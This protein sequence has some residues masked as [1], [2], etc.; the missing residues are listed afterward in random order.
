M[1]TVGTLF[2]RSREGSRGTAFP[3]LPVPHRLAILYLMTPLAVWLVG[4][5][6][7]WFG[8]PAAALLALGLWQAL[9]G[10]WRVS[11]RP[12]HLVLLLIAAGWVM[13]TAAGGVFDVHNF[14]WFKHR[15]LFLDLSNGSWPTY[16]PTYIDAPVLLRYYI[17]YYMV[18][19][20]LSNLFGLATLNWAVP[21]WTWCGV[22]LML[23][24]FTREHRGWTAIL[25]AFILVFFSG[26]DIVRIAQFEGL[27]WLEVSVDLQG[28]P[29]IWLGER[30]SWAGT[31]GLVLHYSPHMGG[32]MWVPQHFIA[33]VLYVLLLVQ[34]FQEPRFLAVS[35]VLL[36]TSLFWSPFV[37]IGLLPMVVA[38]VI[39]NGMRP[40]LKW[41][42]L[43]LALP[44]AGLIVAYLASG[45]VASYP[46]G[47][48]W[49]VYSNVWPKLVR[50]LPMVYLT[51]FLLLAIVIALLRPR[52][53]R[54][55]FYIAGLATLILLPWIFFGNFN[56]LLLRATIPSLAL[57]SYYCASTFAASIYDRSVKHKLRP[58][59]LCAMGIFLSVGAVTALLELSW[60]NNDHDF[61]MRRYESLGAQFSTLHVQDSKYHNQYAAYEVTGLFRRLLRES[62]GNVRVLERGEQIVQAR[63][64]VYMTKNRLIYVFGQCSTAEEDTRFFLHVFPLNPEHLPGRVHATLDF[65][66]QE[67]GWRAEK[68]CLIVRELPPFAI[69]RIRTGQ[70]NLSG[71]AHEWS[72]DYYSEQYKDRLLE[73]A[74][75]PLLRAN[76]D[77]YHYGRKL[78]YLKS[79]CSPADAEG[80]FL[81]H[82]V[83]LDSNDLYSGNKQ[84][85]FDEFDFDFSATGRETERCTMVRELPDYP[86]KLIRTGQYRP[87]GG[88]LWEGTFSIGE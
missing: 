73:E 51:E 77:V 6:Q 68:Q 3:S 39:A 66:F 72:G 74:G 13:V 70:T 52:L 40:L 48:V 16:L 43:C 18:P 23:I 65:D 21:L 4:W 29:R 49:D 33:G 15:G 55:P 38:L 79:P 78:I 17:G 59:L 20:L 14:D 58:V 42:N 31:M 56:D 60:A 36:A 27:D 8:I 34:L 1:K 26:M 69:G 50:V 76:F 87:Q 80:S 64:N 83:P 46:F 41:Q 37:A 61:D 82:V 57:L 2:K 81:L 10:S 67:F 75:E 25:A 54:D 86:I 47:W 19:G 24:L 85:G 53:I 35:G 32:M 11:L 7:W 71:T 12:I 62:D 88:L 28:W 5:F 30:D 22:A 45:S 9:S 84:A 44:I 63:F